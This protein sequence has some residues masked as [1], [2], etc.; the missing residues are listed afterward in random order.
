MVNLVCS[1]LFEEDSLIGSKNFSA[2]V[3]VTSPLFDRARVDGL[4]NLTALSGVLMLVMDRLKKEGHS[5]ARGFL[6][7]RNQQRF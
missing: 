4:G 5:L 3:R 2:K 6:D 7:E 1:P